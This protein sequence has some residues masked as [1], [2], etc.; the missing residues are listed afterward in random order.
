MKGNQDV[1]ILDLESGRGTGQYSETALIL[2]ISHT[3]TL[4]VWYKILIS[5]PP[6]CWYGMN[7]ILLVMV[8]IRVSP[9]Q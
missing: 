6:L 8:L 5:N 1:W 9:S 7:E 4:L 3:H 2:T